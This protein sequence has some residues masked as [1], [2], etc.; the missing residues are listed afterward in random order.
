MKNILVVAV[1]PDDETLGCGGTLLR[2]K[3]EGKKIHWL[4]MT[5]IFAKENGKYKTFN[6]WKQEI[7]WNH[8][9]IVLPEFSMGK[10]RNRA[11]EIK[12]VR[13][14]YGFDTVHEFSFPA[15]CLDQISMAEMIGQIS[16]VMCSVCPD[17]VFLP[18][19][20]DVHS[21]HRITFDAAYSCTKSFRYPYIKKVLMMETLS[22]TEFAPCM[23]DGAFFPNIFIDISDFINQKIEIMEFYRG[24]TAKHPFPRS[25]D[26]MRALA[27]HR[28]ASANCD[29]AESFVLLKE[30]L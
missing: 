22:E 7:S 14:V 28:G 29:Y 13:Q 4:I 19:K 3:S 17:T 15:M 21:D 20:S 9:G 23:A 5:S 27:F 30:F 25:N 10:V 26:N 11:E 12:K 16:E 8:K 6:S 2:Y 18:F 1:H 24:E